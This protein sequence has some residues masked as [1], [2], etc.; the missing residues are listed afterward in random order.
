MQSKLS[1]F[2]DSI[3]LSTIAFFIS[4][5]T[6]KV[7]IKNHIIC[8]LLGAIVFALCIKIILPKNYSEWNKKILSNSEHKHME[9]CI[10]A[11]QSME[12]AKL[13][14]FFK[15]LFA[16]TYSV[17]T[18]SNY[19]IIDG[20]L[21]VAFDYISDKSSKR[22]VLDAYIKASKLNISE[23]AIFTDT[24]NPETTVYA[25]NLSGDK[26]FFF[27]NSDTYALMKQY[28]TFP[29]NRDDNTK[30]KKLSN[31]K[32]MSLSRKKARSFLFTS[33]ILYFSSLFIPFT[34]Y[35][36]I[37]ASISLILSIICF[38]MTDPKIEP[39]KSYLFA[40]KNN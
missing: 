28:S 25:K 40:N 24:Q 21:L 14:T 5:A 9:K 27:D 10:F 38:M 36:L 11:L 22:V 3:F 26:I 4:M 31:L 34:G 6:F 16:K 17:T 2:L 12:K 35:Y 37:F 33:F 19:I 39:K 20:K 29:I 13:L 8:L 23:I 15:Q 32:N 7:L 18:T 1:V 30:I